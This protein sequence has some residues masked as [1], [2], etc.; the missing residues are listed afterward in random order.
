MSKLDHAASL[1]SSD[2]AAKQKAT[3]Q[4]RTT[5]RKSM[6]TGDNV[7]FLRRKVAK[8]SKNFNCA[9]S[10]SP[11]AFL[12]E[13]VRHHEGITGCSE[14]IYMPGER[15]N[16]KTELLPEPGITLTAP[17]PADKLI[18]PGERGHG[19]DSHHVA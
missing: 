10:Y 2:A 15:G 3:L 7:L 17:V 5:N 19:A 8:L 11:F 1:T 18:L 12:P 14:I 4:Q 13:P 16:R 6:N 9:Q